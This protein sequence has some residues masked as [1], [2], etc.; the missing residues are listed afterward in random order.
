MSQLVCEC[1]HLKH[2]HRLITTELRV[3]SSAL[4]STKTDFDLHDLKS[5][6]HCK[7]GCRCNNFRVR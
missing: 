2:D 3:K 7:E 4:D 1:G 6:L 5:I